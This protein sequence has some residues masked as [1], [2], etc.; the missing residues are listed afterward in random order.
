MSIL[1]VNRSK[2]KHCVLHNGMITWNYS[3]D[4]FKVNESFSMFKSNLRNFYLEKLQKILMLGATMIAFFFLTCLQLRFFKCIFCWFWVLCCEIS[5]YFFCGYN[6]D[7]QECYC[8]LDLFLVSATII[9]KLFQPN[10]D[11]Y[12]HYFILIVFNQVRF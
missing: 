9:V 2:T 4:V 1:R 3:P 7:N 6:H 10:Y 8:L 12:C 5:N 11:Y